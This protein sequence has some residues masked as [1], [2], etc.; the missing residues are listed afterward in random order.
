VVVHTCNSSST[1]E[2]EA[3]GSWVWAILG[4]IVKPCLKKT[5]DWGCSSV[6][7]CFYKSVTCK[8][9]KKKELNINL[10]HDPACAG[11]YLDITQKKQQ[12][13]CWHKVCINMFIKALFTAAKKWTQSKWPLTSWTKCGIIQWNTL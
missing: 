3:A 9:K 5:K 10:A 1:W 4:Y 12:H 2:A 8:K 7:A 11:W 6:I 13:I